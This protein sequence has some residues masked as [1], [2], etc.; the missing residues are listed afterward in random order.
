MVWA[1]A[2]GVTEMVRQNVRECDLSE[3]PQVILW[4]LLTPLRMGAVLV[5]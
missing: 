4:D 3:S 5:V 1:E 2:F